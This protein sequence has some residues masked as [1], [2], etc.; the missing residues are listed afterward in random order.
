MADKARF[1]ITSLLKG[2]SA[3]AQNTPVSTEGDPAAIARPALSGS[4]G[5]GLEIANIAA[6]PDAVDYAQDEY[7]CANFTPSEIAHCSKEPVAKAA[8]QSLLS[9]KRA[10]VKSGAVSVPQDGYKNI[11]IAFD[12]DGRPCYL[13]CLLS[14]SETGTMAAAV[15]FWP[16]AEPAA[17]AQTARAEQRIIPT[18]ARIVALL[19]VLSLLVLFGIG[20]WKILGF[21]LPHR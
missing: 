6:L 9:A 13:G 15:C 19:V 1:T 16:G 20:F 5:L 4:K 2:K 8:F 11:E 14:L 18:R 7:Y 17:A 3:V 12:S 10:I 21:L